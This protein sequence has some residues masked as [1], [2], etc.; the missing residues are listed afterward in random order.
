MIKEL[1]YGIKKAANGSFRIVLLS[2][3]WLQWGN[4]HYRKAVPF[5]FPHCWWY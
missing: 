2:L 4:Q 5:C 3:R 1:S